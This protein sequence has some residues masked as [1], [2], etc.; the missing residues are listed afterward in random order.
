MTVTVKIKTDSPTGKR[1]ENELRQY[2]QVVEFIDINIVSD[3]HPEGYPTHFDA[4][5]HVSTS[6]LINA[7]TEIG[8]ALVRKLESHRKVVKIEYPFPVDSPGNEIETISVAESAKLAF[9]RLG[10]KYNCKFENKYTR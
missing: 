2:P 1:L 4:F 6:I 3:I 5:E 10:E 8:K 7:N 9:E